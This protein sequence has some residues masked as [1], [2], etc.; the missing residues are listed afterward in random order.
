[1]RL[2]GARS[3]SNPLMKFVGKRVWVLIELRFPGAHI[4]Y[5]DF[6][7]LLS[8]DTQTRTFKCNLAW[9]NEDRLDEPV[10][11]TEKS[12]QRRCSKVEEIPA[13]EISLVEPVEARMTEELFEVTDQ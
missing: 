10:H 8:Y 4:V 9:I 7:R 12:M 11:C 3:A 6:A 13:A 2:Y 1:M 5:P